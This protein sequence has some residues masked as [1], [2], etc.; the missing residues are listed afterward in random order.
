MTKKK[1]QRY[2]S[3][4]VFLQA[5]AITCSTTNV[6]VMLMEFSVFAGRCRTT[7]IRVYYICVRGFK[8]RPVRVCCG[9][10]W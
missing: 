2:S 9:L 1:Y 6:Y 10:A 3:E 7:L 4:P 5:R 8:R